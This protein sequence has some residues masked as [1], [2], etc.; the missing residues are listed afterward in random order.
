MAERPAV[1]RLRGTVGEVLTART[2][3]GQ[4][5]RLTATLGRVASALVP[6]YIADALQTHVNV[7]FRA[8]AQLRQ[9]FR[10]GTAQ[11]NPHRKNADRKYPDRPLPLRDQRWLSEVAKQIVAIAV[12]QVKVT[13]QD[14][15]RRGARRDANRE[16]ETLRRLGRT[17]PSDVVDTIIRTAAREAMNSPWPGTDATTTKRVNGYGSRAMKLYQDVV[18]AQTK[19]ARAKAMDRL[20]RGLHD[21]KRGQTRVDGGSVGK[22]LSRINRT[23]QTRISHKIAREIA[24]AAGVSFMYWRLSPSHRWYGGNEICEKLAAQTGFG[25]IAALHRAGVVPSSVELEGLYLA[26]DPPY[27]PHPNC[28]CS[29]VSWH[30]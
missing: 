26:Q 19:A 6:E 11:F 22:A 23:E 1:A 3:S 14:E 24:L 4:E 28:M 18:H 12:R 17:L 21:P 29:L 27:V 8:E 16:L 10:D 25:V 20:R 7:Q 2:F 30:P 15:F 13:M 9:I 5:I